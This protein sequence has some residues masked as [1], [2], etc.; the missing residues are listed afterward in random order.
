MTKLKLILSSPS[1]L[2]LLLTFNPVKVFGQGT[3]ITPD[4][5]VYINVTLAAQGT[6]AVPT[7][8]MAGGVG[9]NR[10][11]GCQTYT[12]TYQATGAGALTSIDFQAGK[13]S[14]TTV[15]FA[16]WAG[17]IS[18]GI[19][20]NTS[21]TGATSTF[22]TGCVSGGACTVANSWLQI[23]IT[24]GTFVGTI[25]G[26]LYGYKTGNGGGGGGLSGGC[27]GTAATPCVVDG[28]TAAGN[29]PT[30]PPVLVAGQD[31]APGN[32]RTIQTDATGELIPSNASFVGA[33]GISNT[34]LSPTGAGGV[35]LYSRIL[36]YIFGGTTNDRQ[37][38]CL[39]QAVAIVAPGTTGVLITGTMGKTTKIC[40]MHMSTTATG[41]TLTITSGTGSVCAMGTATIDAYVVGVTTF[42]MDYTPLSPLKAAVAGDDICYTFSPGNVTADL[43]V[44]Y[45]QI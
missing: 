2:L 29:A 13:S 23:V 28:P 12:L 42:A 30:K 37:F 36:P 16:T 26:V 24:R 39:F 38:A 14:T 7:V 31:G 18:T 22:S 11:I 3:V 43:T 17:T 32:V 45:A 35:Q 25:N 41:S 10:T 8:P 6:V 5:V 40:H 9:D 19:N 33:D 27:I 15:T 21:S 1:L 20:P 34:Q 4:C 44:I